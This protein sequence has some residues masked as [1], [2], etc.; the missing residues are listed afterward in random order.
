MLSQNRVQQAYGG[1]VIQESLVTVATRSVEL[2]WGL[3]TVDE[4]PR[5]GT[6]IEG[7]ASCRPR[8]GRTA[9]SPPATPPG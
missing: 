5:P 7:L 2:G 6:T 9:G 4:P 1:G 8:S 3:A